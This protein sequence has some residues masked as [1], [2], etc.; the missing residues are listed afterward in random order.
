MEH[1]DQLLNIFRDILHKTISIYQNYI[2]ITLQSTEPDV[3]SDGEF[4]ELNVHNENHND[5]DY[6]ILDSWLARDREKRALASKTSEA[7]KLKKQNTLL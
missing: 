7:S 3:D 4:I 6:T 2:I 1:I 5:H